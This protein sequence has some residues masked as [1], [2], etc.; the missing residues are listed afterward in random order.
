MKTEG[1]VTMVNLSASERLQCI[2]CAHSTTMIDRGEPGRI[3]R[4]LPPSGHAV[5]IAQPQ[6]V[7][8]HLITV[9]PK[10]EPTDWCAEFCPTPVSTVSN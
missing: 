10:V 7:A 9:W 8:V 4:R 1:T 5:P 6:G 2:D 3:C